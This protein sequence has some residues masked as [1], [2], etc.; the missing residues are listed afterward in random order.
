MIYG[1]RAWFVLLSW[2][3]SFPLLGVCENVDLRAEGRYGVVE[4]ILGGAQGDDHVLQ[5]KDFS[6][7]L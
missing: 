4:G 7:N 6:A 1:W 3:K 5:G 2:G